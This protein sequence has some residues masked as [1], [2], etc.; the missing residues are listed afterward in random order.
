VGRPSCGRFVILYFVVLGRRPHANAANHRI[1]TG[2]IGS[3]SDSVAEMRKYGLRGEHPWVGTGAAQI[4]PAGARSV[5]Q[6]HHSEELL[7][8]A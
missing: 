7:Q 3:E 4:T 1:L 5:L 8:T 2:I 6:R